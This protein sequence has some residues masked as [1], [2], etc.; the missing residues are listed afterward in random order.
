MAEA[1]RPV[2]SSRPGER[3]LI[4]WLTQKNRAYYLVGYL[5]LLAL[6]L[7]T[8]FPVYWQLATSL[9]ADVDLFS[10]TVTLVP[11]CPYWR[12]LREDSRSQLPL[13]PPA[14]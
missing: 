10:P 5:L 8:L 9:R 11:P 13:P 6:A 1:I 12:A 3:G 2:E 14:S 7:W 4:L